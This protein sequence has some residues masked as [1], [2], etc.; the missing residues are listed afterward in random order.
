MDGTLRVGGKA[1][2]PEHSYLSKV[3]PDFMSWTQIQIQSFAVSIHI[4]PHH[5]FEA[6][7]LV[8]GAHVVGGWQRCVSAILRQEVGEELGWIR[9]WGWGGSPK[10]CQGP[11]LQE[12]SLEKDP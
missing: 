3:L 6:K 9:L 2:A 11:S 12:A 5:P 4:Q 8:M 1:D 7:G 10:G